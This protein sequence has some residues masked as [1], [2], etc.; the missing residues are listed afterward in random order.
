MS[1]LCHAYIDHDQNKVEI[2]L[3]L[4]SIYLVFIYKQLSFICKLPLQNSSQKQ[5]LPKQLC[6]E[7]SSVILLQ[8]YFLSSLNDI[9]C[10]NAV[11]VHV[12]NIF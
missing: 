4:F 11:L 7:A 10:T 3:D 9:T 6:L 2:S 5:T 1:D 12:C 8:V